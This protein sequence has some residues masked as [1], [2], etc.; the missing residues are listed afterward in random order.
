M[1]VSVT[2][3]LS[4]KLHQHAGSEWIFRIPHQRAADL[5]HTSTAD[6]TGHLAGPARPSEAL[7]MIA[8]ALEQDKRLGGSEMGQLSG[9]FSSQRFCQSC[10]ILRK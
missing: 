4:Q 7:N 2:P 9:A 3:E 8:Y 6:E 10:G 5:Q 1:L